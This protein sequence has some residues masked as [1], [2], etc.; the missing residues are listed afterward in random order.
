MIQTRQSAKRRQ[1]R[2]TAGR[3]FA[4]TCPC[5]KV[6]ATGL[7]GIRNNGSTLCVDCL[8]LL[9]EPTF[10][11]RLKTY[12]LVAGLSVEELAGRTRLLRQLL[13]D[14]ERGAGTPNWETLVKLLRVLGTEMVTV[15]FKKTR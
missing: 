2:R 8:S 6:I 15:G 9:P 5:G 13:S 1:Q 4:V 11:Q 14:Y 10:A 3:R 7:P 12:R